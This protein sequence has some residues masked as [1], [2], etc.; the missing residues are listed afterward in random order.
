MCR[1]ERIACGSGAS[2]A[3]RR[4]FLHPVLHATRQCA[5]DLSR[6]DRRRAPKLPHQVHFPLVSGPQL[7]GAATPWGTD[8]GHVRCDIRILASSG[9]QARRVAP[10]LAG[11][12]RH[13]EWVYRPGG[14]RDAARGLVANDP[15]RG[16]RPHRPVAIVFAL[17]IVVMSPG[18]PYTVR[19][20]LALAFFMPDARRVVLRLLL[21]TLVA[22][23]L[24]VAVAI[25]L[26]GVW[27][28][29][30]LPLEPFV[31]W[32]GLLTMLY[33]PMCVGD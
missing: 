26:L 28:R 19:H 29:F 23:R 6:A 30:G 13:P 33:I 17:Q 1:R 3:R 11:P 32:H 31:V 18:D 12:R 2:A 15:R 22:R 9:Y 7:G 4:L 5:H 10:A 16:V 20:P 27:L 14:G 8:N 24:L 25:L 21:L